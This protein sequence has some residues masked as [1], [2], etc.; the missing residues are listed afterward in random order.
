MTVLIE[1]DL[2]LLANMRPTKGRRGTEARR[3]ETVGFK[4]N[5]NDT[6]ARVT[7]KLDDAA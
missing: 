2:D 6:A 7:I 1:H 5:L 4:I 3:V